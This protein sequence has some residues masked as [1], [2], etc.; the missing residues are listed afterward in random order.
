MAAENRTFHQIGYALGQGAQ[1]MLRSPFMS[2]IVVSTMMIALATLGFLLL[3]LNDLNTI[4]TEVAT[5]LKI[6]VFVEDQQDPDKLA[7]DIEAIQ[8]VVAPVKV[9]TKE[10]ALETMTQTLKDIKGLF[11]K[12]NNP[13]PASIEVGLRNPKKMT[14][15]DKEIRQLPGV[16][17][18]QSN[19]ELAEQIQ[20]VQGGIQLVG[21]IIAAILILATLAIVI[22]TIQLAV[23]QRHQE[24][25]IMR[26]VGAP[27][28]FVRLPFLLEGLIFGILSAL[29]ASAMLVFWRLVPYTQLQ[30]WFSF[31]PLPGSLMP[32]VGIDVLLL[33]TG[34]LMG[35]IGST[36]SVHRY[37][38]IELRQA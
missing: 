4:S 10:E 29:L 27:Q 31:L 30:H 21:S 25:E 24:I 19:Q 28:W 8:G 35:L 16:E 34:I 6:V 9:V 3:V 37:L 32:L 36:L 22:N 17:D 15:T 20:Q 2:L 38:R 26:L 18:T 7:H 23:H 5:Q 12:D 14:D 13:F 33:V 1:N 11:N